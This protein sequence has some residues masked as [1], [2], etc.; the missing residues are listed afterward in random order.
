MTDPI[1]DDRV[2]DIDGVA[3]IPVYREVRD[4]GPLTAREIAER[5]TVKQTTVQHA[6]RQLREADVVEEAAALTLDT[7]ATAWDTSQ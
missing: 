5:T 3:V 1:T 6:I 2:A 7:R 4:N